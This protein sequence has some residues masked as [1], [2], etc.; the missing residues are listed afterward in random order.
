MDQKSNPEESK[1]SFRSLATVH[2]DMVNKLLITITIIALPPVVASLYRIVDIGW[3]NIMYFHGIGYLV[4]CITAVFHKKILFFH[5]ALITITFAFLIGCI[6]T[7]NMGLIGSG[8]IFMLFSI[9][10]A[11]MFLG[12]RYGGVLIMA[13]LALLVIV[14]LG[15]NQGWILFEYFYCFISSEPSI[16]EHNG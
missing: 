16:R 13:S 14:A 4:I 5:K 1:S 11:T 6:A 8:V 10:L 12:V 9:I 7:V 15:V 3:Q 2:E